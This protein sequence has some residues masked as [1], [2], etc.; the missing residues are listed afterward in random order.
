[1]DSVD[2]HLG[3]PEFWID[4]GFDHRLHW[5]VHRGSQ[6]E[7][8]YN[9][10]IKMTESLTS[11]LR[12]LLWPQLGIVVLVTSLAYLGK[13]P[14]RLLALP[15][16]DKVMHFL[17]FGLVA[18][19][20][21]FW[22]RSSNISARSRTVWVVVLLTLIFIEEGFQSLSPNRTLEIADMACDLMGVLTFWSLGH[23]ITPDL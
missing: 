8:R 11:K 20:L 4:S 16:A 18:F 12:W 5:S 22:G 23:R 2:G 7:D 13:I 15:Y 10:I 17:L 1:M 19:W 6:P 21:S 3:T 9:R 14:M